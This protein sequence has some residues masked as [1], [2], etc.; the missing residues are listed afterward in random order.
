MHEADPSD[1]SSFVRSGPDRGS[2]S[3]PAIARR[4]AAH[5]YRRLTYSEPIDHPAG[6]N[7]DCHCQYHSEPDGHELSRPVF[8]AEVLA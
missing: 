6:P 5:D 8:D 2:N 4:Y 3:S 7:G 1:F